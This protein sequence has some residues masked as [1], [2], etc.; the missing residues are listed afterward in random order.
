MSDD[1]Q[2]QAVTVGRWPVEAKVKAGARGAGAAGAVAGFVLWLL[3]RYVFPG[4]VPDEVDALVF[5]VVPWALA[6]A[7]SYVGGYLA[8]HTPRPLIKRSP[9][10]PPSPYT[11]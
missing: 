1:Q 11:D 8:P 4:G 6:A 7:A 5:L 10:F 3:A 2:D 9:S